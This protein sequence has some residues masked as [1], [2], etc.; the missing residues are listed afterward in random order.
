MSKNLEYYMKL[1]YKIEINPISEEDGGGFVACIPQL[2]RWAYLGIGKTE[3]DAIK[4]L[5]EVKRELFQE[6]LKKGIEIPE[7]EIEEKTYSGRILLRIPPRLHM[8]LT[9]EARKEGT[10]LNQYIRSLLER[11]IDINIL[12]E[13]LINEILRY[14]EFTE[15]YVKLEATWKTLSTP[16]NAV[17]RL[18]PEEEVYANIIE[19]PK[20]PQEENLAKILKF[21]PNLKED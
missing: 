15:P 8:Q 5:E 2:G 13:N 4:N 11:K 14:W 18:G 7:P 20:I 6:Y 3:I 12:S 17:E 9:K 19:Y 16:F 10:S 1:R 21:S